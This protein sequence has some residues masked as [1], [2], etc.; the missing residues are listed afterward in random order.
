MLLGTDAPSNVRLIP[1]TP[2]GV[3]P[4]D[5]AGAVL[6][7]LAAAG[8]AWMM[9]GR[10]SLRACLYAAMVLGEI[11]IVAAVAWVTGIQVL[12]SKS[13]GHDGVQG[14][15]LVGFLFAFAAGLCF[16]ISRWQVDLDMRCPD[17]LGLPGMPEVRGK[18]HDVMLDPR[19]I[20]SI[21]FRGHGVLVQSRWSPRFEAAQPLFRAQD[22]GSPH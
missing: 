8:L 6:R 17:C 16:A 18:S 11:V 2:A 19:E 10:R 9:M 1:L 20:E 5:F 15:A 14:L 4:V 22:S 7:L 13:W 12:A 3:V 21:C